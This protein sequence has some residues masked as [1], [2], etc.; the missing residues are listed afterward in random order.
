ME[1]STLVCL[2]TGGELTPGT[3]TS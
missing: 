1:V 2:K 3:Y